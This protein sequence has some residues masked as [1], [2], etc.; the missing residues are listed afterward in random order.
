[1]S[2]GFKRAVSPI[3]AI[4]RSAGFALITLL[5]SG[6]GAGCHESG[7]D[8][9]ISAQQ[10]VRNPVAKDELVSTLKSRDFDRSISVLN[11]VKAMQ[12]QGELI[13]VIVDLWSGR[14]IK[15]RG[16]DPDF[17]SHPRIRIEIADVL[18]Q[19]ANNGQKTV[20]INEL[21][22]FVR[23]AIKGGDFEVEVQAVRMLGELNDKEDLETLVHI[24]EGE[25]DRLF[26]AATVALSYDCWTTQDLAD[27]IRDHLKVSNH[28]EYFTRVWKDT[29]VTRAAICPR[30]G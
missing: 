12:Y 2:H 26:Q 17:V 3:N 16:L 25:E 5:M 29:R 8:Q 18:I 7:A 13:P 11:R 27:Q 21:G 4:F 1:M 10:N 15:E 23:K 22:D 14:D 19:A 30:G 28:R 24:A 20:P 9:A 6:V